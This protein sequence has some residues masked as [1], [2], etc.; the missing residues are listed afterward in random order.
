MESTN[1]PQNKQLVPHTSN[2]T[3][4]GL[5]VL[6]S[7]PCKSC[8]WFKFCKHRWIYFQMAPSLRWRRVCEKCFKKEKSHKILPKIPHVW[9]RDKSF[10][11]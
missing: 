8:G 2:Y 10:D 1:N 3:P 11:Q 7:I 6:L 5:M 4:K 9:V